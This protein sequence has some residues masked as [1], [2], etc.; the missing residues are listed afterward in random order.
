VRGEGFATDTSI[1]K[2][3]AQRQRGVPGDEPNDW[4][5][6]GGTTRPVREYLE[7]LET[8]EIPIN[9]P[10]AISLTDPYSSWTAANGPGVFAYCTNDLIDLDAG[11][12]VDVESDS[13]LKPSKK[14]E[15]QYRM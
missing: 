14:E 12:I 7:A 6:P 2:A 8:A 15:K 4:G 13:I 1:I 5:G 11:I 3:D 9:P 10:K